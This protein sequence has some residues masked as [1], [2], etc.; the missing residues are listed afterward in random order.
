M[1]L[2]L[3]STLPWLSR[4]ANKGFVCQIC[5]IHCSDVHY[6]LHSCNPFLQNIALFQLLVAS[7]HLFILNKAHMHHT[8]TSHIMLPSMLCQN[9]WTAGQSLW[10]MQ[11]L[12]PG[13]NLYCSYRMLHAVDF[14]PQQLDHLHWVVSRLC[15]TDE[16]G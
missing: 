13:L 16:Q 11:L 12:L 4:L 7:C 9:I 5:S 1:L 3:T 6:T 10:R 8:V 14:A 2:F 15:C